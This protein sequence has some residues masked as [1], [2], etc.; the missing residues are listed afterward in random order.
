MDKQL[1]TIA[2]L[3]VRRYAVV[4]FWYRGEY[5]CGGTDRI[6][7]I[8][9]LTNFHAR[10][11]L[12]S[13][14]H[15]PQTTDLVLTPSLT[16]A[17]PNAHTRATADASTCTDIVTGEGSVSASAPPLPSP[18]P[19]PPPPSPASAP[20]SA[21]PTTFTPGTP[22]S[23]APS[24]ALEA[25]GLVATMGCTE[26]GRG[27]GIHG[28]ASAASAAATTPAVLV[29]VAGWSTPRLSRSKTTLNDCRYKSGVFVW[30]GGRE[31]WRE[32]KRLVSG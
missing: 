19:P 17:K 29:W 28:T 13:R 31:G 23:A 2:S 10:T 8:V 26:E 9:Y 5:A 25:A 11:Q 18:S 16:V 22:K 4:G 1:S 32:G 14:C 30:A 6:E 24:I 7:F 3:T 21:P 27:H 15:T 12:A 20:P